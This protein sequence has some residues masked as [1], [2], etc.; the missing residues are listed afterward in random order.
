M[1]SQPEGT[2]PRRLMHN[3]GAGA[4]VLLIVGLV[5]MVVCGIPPLVLPFK[6]Y[7]A[8]CLPC[9][10]L[11]GTGVV[12]AL[13]GG[14]MYPILTRQA[15]AALAAFE[16]GEYLAHWTY[17]ADEWERFARGELKE[18]RAGL[19]MAPLL[20]GTIFG[21]LAGPVGERIL[22]AVIAAAAAGGFGFGGAW[23]YA[24][25]RGGMT[26]VRPGVPPEVY[27]G[28]QALYVNGW[29]TA[30]G[31]AGLLRLRSVRFLPGDPATVQFAVGAGASRSEVRVPVPAG[32]EAEAQALVDRLG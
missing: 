29:Y 12:L 1:S 17:T 11:A 13:V 21:V 14:I 22:A 2:R 3:Q 27:V 9:L 32:R 28:E 25:V 24:R 19:W 5:L 30:W 26:R 31:S 4:R 8:V 18:A 20:L 6:E 15:D 7:L 10:V 23:V 16:R